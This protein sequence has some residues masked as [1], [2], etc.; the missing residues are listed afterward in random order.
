MFGWL[1]DRIEAVKAQRKLA[2][3]VDPRSFK[4]MA[5]EIRDLALLASQ[6]NP[7][8]KDIHKLIRSVI[9]EMDRLSELADRPEFRKLSTGKKLL[10]RQGLEESRVQLLE[11]IESA[12]SPTQTLQ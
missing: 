10:L 11:S 2:R 3:Q 9:V 1:K 8:E 12:P 7:R 4:R 5:M 6:L